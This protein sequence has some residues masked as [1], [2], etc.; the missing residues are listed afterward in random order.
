MEA[1]SES[2]TVDMS[3]SGQLV[4]LIRRANIEPEEIGSELESKKEIPACD[5]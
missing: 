2:S 3:I 4:R 5:S 1:G